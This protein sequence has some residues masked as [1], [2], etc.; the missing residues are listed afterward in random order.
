MLYFSFYCIFQVQDVVSIFFDHNNLIMDSHIFIVSNDAYIMIPSKAYLM[1]TFNICF[2][3][4]FVCFGF[5]IALKH[6]RSYS[7][8]TLI[9]E[10]PHRNAMQ[11]TQDMTPHPIIVYRH[12]ADLSLCCPL[13]W[14]VTL[15]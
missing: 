11:Q 5:N 1:S 9:Y 6:L 14:N 2:Y 12:G 7:S 3:F 13:M 10:L 8:G 4:L 15:E